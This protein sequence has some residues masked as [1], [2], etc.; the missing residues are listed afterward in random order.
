MAKKVNIG[1]NIWPFGSNMTDPLVD[2][3]SS[4]H[5]RSTDEYIITQFDMLK[6]NGL[7]ILFWGP[8]GS[9]TVQ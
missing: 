5:S 3:M 7:L 6:N 1:F 9:N 2:H 8:F 4:I